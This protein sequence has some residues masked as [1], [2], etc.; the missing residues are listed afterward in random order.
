MRPVIVNHR[1][2]S[3]PPLEDTF[4]SDDPRLPLALSILNRLRDAGIP[5]EERAGTDFEDGWEELF[6][7][8][9]GLT[10]FDPQR[11]WVNIV[12]GES[13][14]QIPLGDQGSITEALDLPTGDHSA[15]AFYGPRPET[16][17][18]GHSSMGVDI[19]YW[20]YESFRHHA[21][22][23]MTTAGF[24]P[25]DAQ[26]T[27]I[28][29]LDIVRSGERFFI[30]TTASKRLPATTGHLVREA[31]PRHPDLT[32]ERIEFDSMSW[33]WA[34]VNLEGQ[35]DSL[36]VQQYVPMR[37]EYR[38]F[39]IDGRVVTGAGCIEEHTPFDIPADQA[40]GFDTRV[41]EHRGQDSD[42][43]DD[44]ELV[45]TLVN[46]AVAVAS[47]LDAEAD[48]DELNAYTLDVALGPDDKPLVVELN[49]IDVAGF[50]ACD[51]Y[52]IASHFRQAFLEEQ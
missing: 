3:I 24:H 15:V 2:R 32:D 47:D 19:P 8:H 44:P 6:R 11:S 10:A 37:Y 40:G 20:R 9:A 48:E 46:F 23:F 36:L 28:E 17:G 22:R 4:S 29:S 14:G 38:F 42:V 39:V 33:G 43:V 25:D 51:P 5:I 13:A 21:G 35:S 16:V 49:P 45:S 30:K 27:D 52:A 31:N 34:E 41:R 1:A 26:A 12:N 50:Y 7:T 18:I